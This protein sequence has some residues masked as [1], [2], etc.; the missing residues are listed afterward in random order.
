MGYILKLLLKIYNVGIVIWL[1][2]VMLFNHIWSPKKWTKPQISGSLRSSSNTKITPS[3][4]V[5]NF[6][7]RH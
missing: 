4:K 5:K 3:F 6:K 1:N 2:I 7:R